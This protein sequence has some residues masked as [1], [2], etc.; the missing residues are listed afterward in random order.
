M[1]TVI[2]LGGAAVAIAMAFSSCTCHEQARE[3]PKPTIKDLPTGFKVEHK[4]ATTPATTP[5]PTQQVA[6]A[7]T[8]VALPP[9]FPNEVPVFKDSV[10]QGVQ[11]LPQ[12][13]HNVIFRT[14]AP[15]AEVSEFY[16]KQLKGAGWNV[17]QEFKRSTRSFA[18]YEKG[19]LLAHV[20][21]GEDPE[22]PGQQIIA[23]MYQ[24]KPKLDF[25]E[26]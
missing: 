3:V 18:T 20:T 22:N 21:I 7:T 4:A 2:R 11:D 8:P 10:V 13:A 9:D 6:A 5:K 24:E 26:F 14:A 12:N 23:I 16:E 17:T 15:V 25:E 1:R 19:N